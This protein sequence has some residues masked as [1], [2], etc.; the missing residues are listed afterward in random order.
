MIFRRRRRRRRTT[1]GPDLPRAARSERRRLDSLLEE[2]EQRLPK[3]CMPWVAVV[4]FMP[5]QV[6][7]ES[8]CLEGWVENADSQTI[9]EGRDRS[10]RCRAQQVGPSD[11]EWSH[12]EVFD[13]ACD[14]PSQSS[15]REKT[16]DGKRTFHEAE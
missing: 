12:R 9:G 15:L 5:R 1:E 10:A 7:V 3:P 6:Q 14:T 4:A 13:G 11:Y 16:L 2:T 8:G